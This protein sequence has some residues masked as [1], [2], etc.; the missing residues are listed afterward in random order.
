M[1]TSFHLLQSFKH[2]F[3]MLI[4]EKLW[5]FHDVRDNQLLILSDWN[6]STYNDNDSYVWTIEHSSNNLSAS[7]IWRSLRQ[8]KWKNQCTWK[9][10]K[11]NS[12]IPFQVCEEASLK[13]WRRWW[14]LHKHQKQPMWVFDQVAVYPRLHPLPFQTEIENSR[15]KIKGS[16]T[17]IWLIWRNVCRN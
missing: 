6:R 1:F 2:W 11:R 17:L 5:N 16:E 13:Q 12:E 8:K 7:K 4:C 3:L 15:N 14:W 9:K 10:N